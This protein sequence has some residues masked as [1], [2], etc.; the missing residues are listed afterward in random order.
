[1]TPKGT[2]GPA[3][4]LR[5]AIDALRGRLRIPLS[6]IRERLAQ[7]SDKVALQIEP[8]SPGLRVR[9]DARA[10]GAPIG[11]AARIDVDGVHVDGPRR[12]IRIRLSEVELSTP[13]DAPG[14]LA[15]AM[16]P[17]AAIRPDRRIDLSRRDRHVRLRRSHRA[18]AWDPAGRSQ[19]SPAQHGACNALACGT[20]AVARGN[21]AMSLLRPFIRE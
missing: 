15:D 17:D 11:F 20:P 1:M 9:G 19:G 2:R 10:L 3:Q 5:F 14:P 16:G 21:R 13:P 8:A 7:L 6:L 4:V 18:R 12:T